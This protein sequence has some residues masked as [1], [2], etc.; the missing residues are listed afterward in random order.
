[1]DTMEVMCE[2][3][4]TDEITYRMSG[5]TGEEWK[6]KVE[7]H[8]QLIVEE[9]QKTNPAHGASRSHAGN[10]RPSH[11]HHGSH[12]TSSSHAP[13]GYSPAGAP[14]SVQFPAAQVPK[15][16]SYVPTQAPSYMPEY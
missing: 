9:T 16:S 15:T 4:T 12:A 7:E 3:V 8:L 13:Q 5:R 2:N 1:M 6:N 14:S 11:G 10:A